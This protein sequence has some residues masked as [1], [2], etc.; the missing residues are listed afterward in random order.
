M[1]VI[2]LLEEIDMRLIIVMTCITHLHLLTLIP[3]FHQAH[4]EEMNLKTK[5]RPAVTV[6]QKI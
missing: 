1:I 3:K 6:L 4:F 2:C 5:Y